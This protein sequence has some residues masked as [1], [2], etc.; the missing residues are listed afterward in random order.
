MGLVGLLTPR[1][2]GMRSG[3]RTAEGVVWTLVVPGIWDGGG[4]GA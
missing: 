2:R 3:E 4:G 1:K